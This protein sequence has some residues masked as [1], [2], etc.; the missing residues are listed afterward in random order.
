MNNDLELYTTEELVK[1]ILNRHTFQGVIIHAERDCK[2][3]K[4]DGERY[5][6]LHW[7][8]NLEK[9]EIPNLLERVADLI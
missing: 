9:T 1:E 4:W 3:R 8:T 5:F 2:N 6:K 7:N